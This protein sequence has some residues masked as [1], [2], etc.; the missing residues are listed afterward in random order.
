MSETFRKLD[1]DRIEVTTPARKRIESSAKLRL[2]LAANEKKIAQLGAV[3]TL[4]RA[5]LN[6]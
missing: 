5:E 6:K 1:D 3:N 4:I 2:K